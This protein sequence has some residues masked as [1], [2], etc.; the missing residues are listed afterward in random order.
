MTK[1]NSKFKMRN[2]NEKFLY[3]YMNANAPT[4]YEVSGQKVW[5]N[6]IEK[7]VDKTFTDAYGKKK[8]HLCSKNL[9]QLVKDCH[10]DVNKD[11]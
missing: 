4:G 7:Y 3:D 2:V 9:R 6:Y 1:E 5:L 10:L 11:K 8:Y